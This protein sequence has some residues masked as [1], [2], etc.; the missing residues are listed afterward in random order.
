MNGLSNRFMVVIGKLLIIPPLLPDGIKHSIDFI[1]DGLSKSVA[2][3]TPFRTI[4]SVIGEYPFFFLGFLSHGVYTPFDARWYKTSGCSQ[5]K[6]APGH[7]SGSTEL[8]ELAGF[9]SRDRGGFPQRA[10]SVG[11]AKKRN[12]SKR[13]RSR[14]RSFVQESRRPPTQR[15]AV[16]EAYPRTPTVTI[17]LTAVGDTGSNGVQV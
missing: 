2:T 8:P 17:P 10:E 3:R 1:P 6:H 11:G 7:R 14:H 4:R 16:E 13:S 12:R 5:G 9:G 15:T